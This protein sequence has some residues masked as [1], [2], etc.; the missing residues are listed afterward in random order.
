MIFVFFRF[1]LYTFLLFLLICFVV[2]MYQRCS[3]PAPK[4][5]EAALFETYVPE[6][7]VE[8]ALHLL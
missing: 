3:A 6:K 1:V 4:A 2:I 8:M 7:P 5:E